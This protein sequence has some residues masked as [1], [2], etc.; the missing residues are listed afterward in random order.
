MTSVARSQTKSYLHLTQ[1]N[2]LPSDHV[3]GM[4]TDRLG[5]LWI[6]TDKGVTKYNG[7]EFRNFDVTSG[8]VSD[9]TWEMLEDSKGRIWLA[10][11][12]DKIGYIYNDEYYR[13]KSDAG[14]GSV[15]PTDMKSYGPGIVFS[16]P[17]YR[18]GSKHDK[19]CITE[20]DSLFCAELDKSAFQDSRLPDDISFFGSLGNWDEGGRYHYYIYG[21]YIHKVEFA[22]N[23]N[24]EYYVKY[25]SRIPLRDTTMRMYAEAKT[26]LFGG[27]LLTFFGPRVAVTDPENGGITFYNLDS[28]TN[29]DILYVHFEKNRHGDNYF[30]CVRRNDILRC[31]MRNA[32]PECT[33]RIDIL[34]LLAAGVKPENI[35]TVHRVGEWDLLGT[36]TSGA[37]KNNTQK[38]VTYNRPANLDGYRLIGTL[39]DSA[40]VWYSKSNNTVAVCDTGFRLKTFHYNEKLNPNL[41]LKYSG[42]TVLLL[43]NL[44]YALRARDGAIIKVNKRVGGIFGG[45]T[46]N[47]KDLRMVTRA[48]YLV[49]NYGDVSSAETILD[50]NRFNGCS[51]DTVNGLLYLYNHVKI[52]AADDNE[53]I[54]TFKNGEELA[55]VS[56]GEVQKIT[57][58]P[59]Y[60]NVFILAKEKL[61]LFDPVR[62]SCKELFDNV[63]FKDVFNVL[64]Y[65]DMLCVVSKYGIVLSRISGRGL[66]GKPIVSGSAKD[67]K[68]AVDVFACSGALYLAQ[69]SQVLKVEFPDSLA[70]NTLASE[71]SKPFRFVL[72]H[73]DTA[74]NI[75]T[76]DTVLL[77]QAEDRF[78]LDVINQ[79]G[80]GR[81][82]L[83]ASFSDAG[84]LEELNANEIVVPRNFVPGNY[85]QLYVRANDALNRSDLV[86]IT[87]YIQPH[88]YQTSI[89][90]W[91]IRV[92]AAGIVVILILLVIVFTK[93]VVLRRNEQKQAR[94]ELELRSIYAQINPHFIFNTLNSALLLISKN[95]M[96][97]AYTHISKFSRLLR[98]YLRSSRNKFIA[99]GEE[100]ANLRNYIELQQARFKNRFIYEVNLEGDGIVEK[101]S[102][103]SLLIQPFVENAINHGLLPLETSGRLIVTFS[104]RSQD[105]AIVCVIDDNGIGREQSKND[106]VGREEVKD[107]YGDLIINDLV[108]AFNKYEKMNVHVAYFDKQ[109]PATGTIVTITIKNPHYEQ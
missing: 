10:S 102:I 87:I 84:S 49:L 24:G 31:R 17:S 106:K 4:I 14:V 63:V 72:K 92:I 66:L 1:D 37:W 53:R 43:G 16:T 93:K 103:P 52:L 81:L 85:Y 29:R 15:F 73:G 19:L 35:T 46:N 70:L 61:F 89:G 30:H 64:V 54:R 97:E 47:K 83:F 44:M 109:A 98:S 67:Y 34:P 38:F 57:V 48:G 18:A 71:N 22:K 23:E 3:Y 13:A 5:Y 27:R 60:G 11:F 56:V 86:A 8:L 12:A 105:G 7:Y 90:K 68:D 28:A 99:V 101:Y 94:M 50:G 76:G 25:L 41:A 20:K 77:S 108:N 75:A 104:H 62:N 91:T 2:G 79:N 36:T 9:D 107:S 58:D 33:E 69:A 39:D 26:H 80:L 59:K 55:G 96:D 95:R 65:R 78:V 82:K 40:L 6:C 100:A 88:W 42:D 21:V 45:V 74:T 51:L 32:R